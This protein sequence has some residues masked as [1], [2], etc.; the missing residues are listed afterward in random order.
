MKPTFCPQCA[1]ELID[2]D[3][4]D[5]RVRRACPHCD[6]VH[7][8]NP[9]PVVAAIVEHDGDVILAR[10]KAWPK[11]WYALVTG[12]LE[13]GETAAEAVVREVKEELNLDGEIISFVGVYSFF[14]MNQV[15]LAYHIR[16][17]GEVRLG[18]ELIDYKRV[19][20]EQLKPWP[21]GTGAAVRDWLAAQREVIERKE[22]VKR[23]EI[24]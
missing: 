21:M 9:A 6:F 14:E 23:A 15:I 8:D 7:Y 24:K 11:T 18:E 20:P 10:N 3:D 19:P 2:R 12:F 1:T 16:A 13:R 17:T 5:E 4:L 22:V